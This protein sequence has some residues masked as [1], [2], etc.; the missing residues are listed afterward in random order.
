[1]NAVRWSGPAG[2][3]TIRRESNATVVFYN[4][5]PSQDEDV[6]ASSALTSDSFALFHLGP[7]ELARV[8]QTPRRLSDGQE[9]G[10][11]YYRLYFERVPGFGVS[12]RDEI[13][14]YIDVETNRLFRVW[15]TLEGFA[16]TR[17][18][19]VDVT[20][21]EYQTVG[22]YVF[23]KALVE[24]VRAPIGIKA[25]TW[26]VTGIELNRGLEPDD[27]ASADWLDR[28]AHSPGPKE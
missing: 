14:A 1:V 13:V 9:D 4:G 5:E 3:K 25:H 12:E 22:G 21:T 18:A 17:G 19:T 8:G 15:I 10:R 11:R 27:V 20:F 7:S 2:T 24:R 23:P 6:L 16:T 26:E 28:A